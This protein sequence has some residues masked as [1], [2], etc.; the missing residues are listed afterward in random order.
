MKKKFSGIWDSLKTPAVIV[1]FMTPTL[2]GVAE[3]YHL[4]NVKNEAVAN[5]KTVQAETEL[6]LLKENDKVITAYAIDLAKCQAGI[7][8]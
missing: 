7:G 6:K 4:V 2:G 1:A 8:Q 3:I 5:L